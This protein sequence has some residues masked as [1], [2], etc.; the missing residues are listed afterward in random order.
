M[1]GK[2]RVLKRAKKDSIKKSTNAAR[3]NQTG[4]NSARRVSPSRRAAFEIL[5]RVECEGAFASVLLATE[6]DELR[7]DDRALCHELVMNC[8]RRQ[9]WLDALIEH[10]AARRIASIDAG[11]RVALRLGLYQL[12]FLSRVPPSA[13][14]NESVNLAYEF[15]FR[16]AAG[17]IN[18]VLR[19]ATREP[20][21]DPL[22]EFQDAPPIQKLSIET[23]H[24]AW[25]LERWQAQFGFAETA[26]LARAN[27]DAPPIS[28][29]VC[30]FVISESDALERL[31]A[32]G[33]EIETS[34]L[35]PGAWRVANQTSASARAAVRRAMNEGLIY[36]QDEASQMV[37]RVLN[38]QAGERVSDCCA[39]PGSKTTQIAAMANDE[40]FIVAGD[41]VSSRLKIIEAAAR[42]QNLKS[43]RVALIDAEKE[44]PFPEKSFDRVLLDAPCSG[45]GTLR[46][47]PEIRYRI[48]NRDIFELAARQRRMLENVSRVVRRSGRLVFS[49]CSLEREEGEA[50]IA[51]FLRENGE[52]APDE[53]AISDGRNAGTLRT[54]PHRDDAD[55]FFV[56]AL[57]RR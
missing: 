15:G 29:R 11:V 13:A 6:V 35:A 8:L 41:V 27:N 1:S 44:L 48:T 26:A 40:S 34:K 2:A 46:H 51:E 53:G 43:V 7:T 39:A 52:F 36:L 18:A 30:S 33:V 10:F 47:N 54:F 9:L 32:A 28:F 12:R 45:T 56:A 23:S 21:F 38:A 50:V 3:E 42:K 31:R 20:Q 4:G 49:V 17:F 19:R 22:A 14:V 5:R 16:S 55:G 57:R 25:L 37:A 24:P